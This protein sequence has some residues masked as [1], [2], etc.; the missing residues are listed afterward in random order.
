[1]VYRR[2]T[3][4]RVNQISFSIFFLYRASLHVGG[5]NQFAS[6]IAPWK[7]GLLQLFR[8]SLRVD[9]RL[10]NPNSSQIRRM[11]CMVSQM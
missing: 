11:N 6:S 2:I 5:S 10:I 1:M 9:V 4:I 3:E 8:A 7:S